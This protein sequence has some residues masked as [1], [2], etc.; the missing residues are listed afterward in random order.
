MPNQT[1]PARNGY[2]KHRP[3]SDR[4]ASVRIPENGQIWCEPKSASGTL[5]SDTAWLGRV[6]DI[7]TAGIGLSIS[8]RFEPGA[9]LIIELSVKL[10]LPVRVIHATLEKKGR[11]IIG[12]AF[13]SPLSEEVLREFLQEDWEAAS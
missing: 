3:K 1:I 5:K 12:C 8:R 10:H 7:S 4:R 6:R 2:I 11:W 9:E 13:A